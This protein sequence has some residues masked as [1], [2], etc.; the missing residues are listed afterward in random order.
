MPKVLE[1]RSSGA[2]IQTKAAE[3]QS[4]GCDHYITLPSH[5]ETTPDNAT[6]NT[7]NKDQRCV[8]GSHLDPGIRMDQGK[9]LVRVRKP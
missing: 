9:N 4:L 5:E 8:T 1:I 6:P 7:E 3:L 2:G